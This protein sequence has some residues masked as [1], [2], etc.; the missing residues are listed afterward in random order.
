MKIYQLDAYAKPSRSKFDYFAQLEC[1]RSDGSFL[2]P[3]NFDGRPFPKK[4]R[5]VRLF[6]VEPLWPRADFYHI[7]TGIFVCT[8]SAKR[9]VEPTISEFGEFLPVSIDGE[10]APHYIFN[11][12][13]CGDYIDPASSIW[14]CYKPFP[15]QLKNPASGRLVAP[16]FDAKK[17]KENYIFKIPKSVGIYCQEVFKSLVERHRLLG[18]EFRLAWSD[19]NG[20]IPLRLPPDETTNFVWKRG[21]GNCYQRK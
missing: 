11:V 18:F 8:E 16:A 2:N 5:Q 4:W 14:E 10:S 21:N 12:T 9:V 1:K 17:L 20:A 15:E 19:K 6:F 13:I 7:Q 3:R